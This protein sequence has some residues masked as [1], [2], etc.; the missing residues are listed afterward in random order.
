MKGWV[1]KGLLWAIGGYAITIIFLPIL[2]DSKITAYR[3]ILGAVLWLVTGLSIGSLF[4]NKEVVK[5]KTKRK[6]RR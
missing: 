1:G 5:S 3:L 2:E 6:S 4:Y